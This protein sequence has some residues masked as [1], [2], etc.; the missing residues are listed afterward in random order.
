MCDCSAEWVCWTCEN[1][2]SERNILRFGG[3]GQSAKHKYD[4]KYQRRAILTKRASLVI[5]EIA[6]ATN[7]D[8]YLLAW[9]GMTLRN[10][11]GRAR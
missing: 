9:N 7:N 2:A 3:D 5:F 11:M 4:K 6:K 8:R 1:E 10:V